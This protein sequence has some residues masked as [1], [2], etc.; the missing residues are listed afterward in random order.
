[1][2]S[3]KNGQYIFRALFELE[4]HSFSGKAGLFGVSEI[5]HFC[6]LSLMMIEGFFFLAQSV[7]NLLVQHL[8]RIFFLKKEFMN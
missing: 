3:T 8:T 6:N 7:F 4:N 1:M 2:L 5:Y